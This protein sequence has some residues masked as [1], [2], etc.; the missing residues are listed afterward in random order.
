M[1]LRRIVYCVWIA[2]LCTACA[3][4]SPSIVPTQP[5]PDAAALLLA[6]DALWAEVFA[7][8]APS[9]VNI[10]AD[11]SAADTARAPLIGSG[12]VLDTQ[13]HIA[14]S[15][16]LIA[17][18]INGRA[19]LYVTFDDGA[20]ATAEVVGVDSFSDVAVIRA[21]TPPDRLSPVTFGSSDALA[22]GARV[23]LL[24][25]PFGLSG[26]LTLGS[27]SALGRQLPSAQLIDSG[28]IPGF[29]NP[30]IIQLNA[31]IPPGAAGGALLTLR[32]EVVGIATALGD[33]STALR[34]ISFAVPAR[35]IMRV[36]PELLA[37]G[38]VD[39]AYIGINT[40]P[41]EDG[42]TLAAL[43]EALNLPVTAGVLIR[44]VTP[45]SPAAESGLRGGSRSVQVRNLDVCAGGDVI[46]AVNDVYVRSMSEFL[47][48]LILET[49]PGDT[50]MLTVVRAAET[51]EIPVTLSARPTSGE[52]ALP[53]CAAE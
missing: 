6:E 7:R 44:A 18:A 40:L 25:N 32:G 45:G 28:A 17:P 51:L 4:A 14:A 26:T 37:D 49:R 41:E 10:R 50:V 13:G 2:A 38:V 39:Y 36:A 27:I 53:P 30:S 23:A 52:A 47:T 19:A 5:T 29:Q 35:T 43:A 12:F 15:A 21:A 42:Y 33:G 34:G 31:T 1:T 48:Y 22:V 3:G 46:V 16:S 11:F 24:S 8:V 20:V 9:V